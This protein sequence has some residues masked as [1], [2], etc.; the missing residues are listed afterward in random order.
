MLSLISFGFSL[1]GNLIDIQEP[2]RST[3]RYNCGVE[4]SGEVGCSG[5]AEWWSVNRC[6][7]LS[8]HRT[9]CSIHSKSLGVS[10]RGDSKD[11]GDISWELSE[12]SP[13]REILRAAGDLWCERVTVT[14]WDE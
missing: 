3:R 11:M 10:G 6:L 7:T 13:E 2:Y 12:L 14:S 9:H 8:P 4:R 1:T 5:T